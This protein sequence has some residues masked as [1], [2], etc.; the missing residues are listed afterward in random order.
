MNIGLVLILVSILVVM[1]NKFLKLFGVVIINWI[2]KLEFVL[3]SFGIW[4]VVIVI[5]GIFCIKVFM[6]LV[7][8]VWLVLCWFYGI[9]DVILNVWFE[10]GILVNI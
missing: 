8:V 6:W 10:L 4:N 3:G 7:I 2:G 5:F 1:V 9:I